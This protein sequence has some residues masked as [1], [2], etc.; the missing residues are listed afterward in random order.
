[1]LEMLRVRTSLSTLWHRKVLLSFALK[2]VYLMSLLLMLCYYYIFLVAEE[3]TEQPLYS[4]APPARAAVSQLQTQSKYH[5]YNAHCS[6][7]FQHS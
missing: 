3:T 2:K 1:M 4:F 6:C 7:T 5:Q